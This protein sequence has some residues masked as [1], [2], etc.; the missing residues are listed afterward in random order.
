M[1]G[2]GWP[3]PP[4]YYEAPKVGTKVLLQNPA[5]PVIYPEPT[6]GQA[7]KELAARGYTFW[8][9]VMGFTDEECL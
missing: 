3:E 9:A 4:N 8:L 5:Y 6:F 2:G 7:C 1:T